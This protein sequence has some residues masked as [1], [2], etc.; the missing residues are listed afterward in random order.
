MKKSTYLLSLCLVIILVISISGCEKSKACASESLKIEKYNAIVTLP[1]ETAK[2]T[3]ANIDTLHGLNSSVSMPASTTE[4]TASSSEPKERL[5]APFFYE[6]DKFGTISISSINMEVNAYQGDSEDEFQ[7]GAGHYNGSFFPGQDGN[8]VMASHSTTYFCP[9]ENLK[10][11]DLVEFDTTYGH[12][13]Y[14]VREIQI[15][16]KKDFNMIVAETDKEQLTMYT[17]YPFICVGHAPNRF[18]VMCDLIASALNT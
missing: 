15:L 18:V 17:C 8:I 16:E 6:G 3:N 4:T 11:D 10:T 7:L 2:E 14:Q 1:D 12:F 5:V 9:L 13:T